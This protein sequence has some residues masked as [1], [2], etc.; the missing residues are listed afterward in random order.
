MVYGLSND[1]VIAHHGVIGMKWGVRRYQPY[2]V[3][4]RGSGKGGNDSAARAGLIADHENWKAAGSNVNW[5]AN[6]IEKFGARKRKME[7]R[8]DRLYEKSLR[9]SGDE[10]RAKLQ[11][12]ASKIV[13]SEKYKNA[14][15]R[16]A[17]GVKQLK[18]ADATIGR[19][20]VDTLLRSR[21]IRNAGV[22]VVINS[23][24]LTPMGAAIF[25]A[26]DIKR[27]YD[28]YQSYKRRA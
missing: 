18:L 14:V 19:E 27:A 1:T 21:A 7:K 4:P 6:D 8:S 9:A 22:N 23:M 28:N 11:E 25:S 17:E 16:H 10:K 15:T 26:Y 12:K 24:I 20:K 13:S 5:A 2:S 3:V